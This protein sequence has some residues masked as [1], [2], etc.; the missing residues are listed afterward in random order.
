MKPLSDEL[1]SRLQNWGEIAFH[2]NP[3]FNL[4]FNRYCVDAGMISTVHAI[5]R[6]YLRARSLRAPCRAA[7]G[8]AST[9]RWLVLVVLDG[10]K[11]PDIEGQV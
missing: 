8:L 2:P 1:A 4:Q 11:E 7:M 9:R 10:T 3:Q 5:A 6:L